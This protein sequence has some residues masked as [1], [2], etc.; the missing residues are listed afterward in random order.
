V[1]IK[2]RVYMVQQNERAPKQRRAMSKTSETATSLIIVTE[3]NHL[4][5]APSPVA[6]EEIKQH[7]FKTEPKSCVQNHAVALLHFNGARRF[8]LV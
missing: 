1:A 7:I 6:S 2:A 4:L 5:R 8:I 3:C